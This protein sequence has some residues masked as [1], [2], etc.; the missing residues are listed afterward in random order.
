MMTIITSNTLLL[1]TLTLL[2]T[3]TLLL[4]NAQP[5]NIQKYKFFCGASFADIQADTC[6]DRQW[7]PSSS[8]D[9]CLV[10]GHTCFANTPC[11]ARTI[12]GVSVPTYSLS[13]NPE[14][15]D[16][17]DKMFCG[18]DYSDAI[19]TCEAGGETA[20]G[21][22]CPNMECP[23][24]LTCFIDMP[25]SYYV[26]TDPLA[27]PLNNVNEVEI[28]EEE[29]D[30]PKPGSLESNYFCGPTFQQAASN[31]SS[32]TWCKTGTSQE[33]PNGETCFVSVNTENSECEINAI[34]KKETLAAQALAAEE[35]A[36]ANNTPLVPTFKP[37]N[38]PLSTTDPKN[39]NFCGIDW[40]DASSNCLLERFCPNGDVDCSEGMTCQEYTNCNAV[41]LTYMPTK[42]P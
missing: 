17:T 5:E 3:T 27:N 37:T 41:G 10:P 34:V 14:Y 25:C 8:D 39:Q 30:L 26:L 33:C 29:L 20:I 2:I 24:G 35:A 28:T 32:K 13:L 6:A 40:Q 18:T 42:S 9:E 16:P 22:H 4:V 12:D 36:A 23:N 31:C 19:R 38:P 21:R 1:G 7:C 15:R 11:D